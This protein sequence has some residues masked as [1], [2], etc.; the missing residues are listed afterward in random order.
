MAAREA[1]GRRAGVIGVSAAR[2]AGLN[3]FILQTP[4]VLLRSTRGHMLAPAAQAS[5]TYLHFNSKI[6]IKKPSAGSDSS[7]L[8][9]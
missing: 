8:K 2:D 9:N 6:L 4:R 3:L 1:G 5:F 7:S